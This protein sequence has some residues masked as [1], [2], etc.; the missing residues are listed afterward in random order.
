MFVRYFIFYLFSYLFIHLYLCAYFLSFLFLVFFC[1]LVCFFVPLSLPIYIYLYI[2]IYIFVYLFILRL[3]QLSAERE[4][5]TSHIIGLE[6]HIGVMYEELVEEFEYKKSATNIL[7]IKDVK[8]SNLTL[9]IQKLKLGMSANDQFITSFKRELGNI[10]SSMIVGKELEE[11]VRMLYKKYVRG[12]KVILHS[13]RMGSEG[14][15]NKAI[16][17]RVHSIIF[18]FLSFYSLLPFLFSLVFFFSFLFFLF[19]SF[20]FFLFLSFSFPLL[21]LYFFLSFLLFFLLPLLTSLLF[22]PLISF[23]SSFL[24]FSARFF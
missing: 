12:E 9:E 1:V 6:G 3:Q 19:F 15:L 20:R 21:F 7:E 5:I 17:K 16:G 2:L 8:I 14:A 13:S 10:A 18:S 11:T 4:P 22:L 23:F 24:C